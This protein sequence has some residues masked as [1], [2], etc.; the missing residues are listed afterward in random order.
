MTASSHGDSERA[1]CGLRYGPSVS[2]YR[3]E[4]HPE[5]AK[6]LAAGREPHAFYLI[7]TVGPFKY[8]SRNASTAV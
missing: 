4:R 5:G 3:R 8:L 6:P 2:F 1:A 7:A